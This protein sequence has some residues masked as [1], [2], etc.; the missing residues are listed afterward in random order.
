MHRNLV[1]VNLKIIK[2][3]ANLRHELED[4]NKIFELQDFKSF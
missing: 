1:E 4:V 3:M 2:F